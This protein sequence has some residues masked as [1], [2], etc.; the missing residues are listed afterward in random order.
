MRPRK[1]KATKKP[2]LAQDIRLAGIAVS[3]GVAHGPLV[4]IDHEEPPIPSYSITPEEVPAQ[5]ARFEAALLTTREQ[6]LKIREHLSGSL[7][8][9]D[10]SIFDAHLLVVEDST[11][12][13]AVKRQLG[14]KL[15]CVEYVYHHI[16]SAYA[17]SM[18]QLDDPY[19][20]E[21]AADIEDIGRRVINN[22]MGRNPSD[23]FKLPSASIILSHDLSPGDTAMLDRSLVLGFVTEAGSRTSH[24]A[25]M[26]RSLKIPGVV[27]LK[28]QGLGLESGV[29]A[30]LDGHEGVLIINPS[31]ATKYEYGQIELRRLAFE[32]KLD[33]LRETTGLT[34]DNRRIFISANVEL[35]EDLPLLK[36]SGAEGI[37]LYRTEFMF[38]NRLDFPSEDEQTETYAKVVEASK[39]HPPIIRTLDIGGDKLPR[40]DAEHSELNPFLGFRAIRYC[41]EHEDIFRT[42]LRAICR[43]GRGERIRILFPMISTIEELTRSKAILKNVQDE[44][45]QQCIPQAN[46]IEIGIMIEVPSAALIV[47]HLVPHA[48]FLSI[49]TNDLVQYTMAVDRTN[50]KVAPLYQ[51]THP[52]VMQLIKRTADA[53]HAHGKWVGVCGEVAGEISLTPMLL[54]LGIDELSMGSVFVP[55]VKKAVQSLHQGDMINLMNELIKLPSA[56]EIFNQV[57]AVAKQAYPDLFD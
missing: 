16:T 33:L 40:N 45:Y 14:T 24:T 46:N 29:P 6:I 5:I 42:Q 49:G 19:L 28:H 23:I 1:G 56:I 57:E 30:I 48:D 36:A 32:E 11:M 2:P 13:E 22:L 25:I 39:P 34:K 9:K 38:L 37:G 21:R 15:Q 12:A 35:P 43:A 17:E 20:R 47:E 4:M 50:E 26:A 3:P 54:G 10:A 55:R 53:A 7:G 41:L 44:L 51:P 18:R 8:E 31:E 52:G 27:G